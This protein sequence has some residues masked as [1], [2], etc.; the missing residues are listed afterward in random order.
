[1]QSQRV[2]LRTGVVI[3]A[4]I[5]GGALLSL[6][7]T[8]AGMVRAFRLLGQ[9]GISDPHA[10]ANTVAGTMVATVGGLFLLPAGV[11]LVVVCSVLLGRQRDAKP[12]PLPQVIENS[13]NV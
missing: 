10:L 2:I 1:M 12:P 3:G 7:W 5:T 8:V 9:N 4:V 11:V 6:C 13:P